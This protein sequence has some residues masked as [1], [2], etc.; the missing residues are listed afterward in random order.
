MHSPGSPR[1]ARATAFLVSQAD[2]KRPEKSHHGG[3][4]TTEQARDPSN[5][6]VLRASVVFL[7]VQIGEPVVRAGRFSPS[8]RDWAAGRWH[9]MVVPAVGF[10]SIDTDPPCSSIRLLTS[11]RPR[12]A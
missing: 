4:E 5:L 11:D 10:D 6:R 8:D 1:Q 2:A 12:P 9:R 7:R 3:T